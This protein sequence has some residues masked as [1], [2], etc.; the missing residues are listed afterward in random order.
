MVIR[1]TIVPGFNDSIENITATAKFMNKAGL[2]EVNILPL[3]HLGASKYDLLEKKYD[4]YDKKAP[5]LTKM[6]EIKGIFETHG[7][8]CYVGSFTPF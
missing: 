7:I 2:S 1:I 4:Y 3:H 6:N 5:S 8:A